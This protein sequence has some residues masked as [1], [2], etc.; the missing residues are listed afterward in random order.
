MS[1][2]NWRHK[3]EMFLSWDCS[4]K[5]LVW[6]FVQGR[7]GILK[8]HPKVR[9]IRLVP[10]KIM[11]TYEIFSILV[12]IL[13]E[14]VK[15]CGQIAILMLNIRDPMTFNSIIL[16]L[17]LF[18]INQILYF[19]FLLQRLYEVLIF[20]GVRKTIRSQWDRYLWYFL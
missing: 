11:Q 12:Y 8:P 16:W 4:I 17:F 6:V 3:S 14:L 5:V 18:P 1:N 9:C 13:C 2:W 20:N 10:L 15:L 19:K 7:Y